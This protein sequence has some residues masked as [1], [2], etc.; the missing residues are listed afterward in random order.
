[1]QRAILPHLHLILIRSYGWNRL[2]NAPI[3]P[4][5]ITIL[6]IPQLSNANTFQESKLAEKGTGRQKVRHTAHFLWPKSVTYLAV[7]HVTK[8]GNEEC[9]HVS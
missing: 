4:T 3:H 6:T 7:Q 5:C 2:P 8:A 9:S 1:M